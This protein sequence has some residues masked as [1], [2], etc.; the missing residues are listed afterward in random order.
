[1]VFSN[2]LWTKPSWLGAMVGLI[3]IVIMSASIRDLELDI[4]RYA[5]K[6]SLT[7]ADNTLKTVNRA[8]YA[9]FM[10]GDWYYKGAKASHNGVNAYIQIPQKLNM[11]KTVQERYLREAICPKADKVELWNQLKHVSLSVHIYTYSK[12]QTVSAKCVNPWAHQAKV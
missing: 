6:S 3:S 1:M 4:P 7:V 8:F 11:D 10:A 9:S 2:Q 5:D 12:A